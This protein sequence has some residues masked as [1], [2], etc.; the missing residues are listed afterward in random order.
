VIYVEYISRRPGVTLT[1]FHATVN[2][3]Q[4]G[5]DDE[6]GQDRLLANVGRTW[7]LGPEPEYFAVWH[8]PDQG[9]DRIDDWDR[10]FREGAAERHERLF[11]QAAR[12]DAAGCYDAL[13]EPIR[14][15]GGTYYLELFRPTGSADAIARFYE[16]RTRDRPLVL[17]LLARRVGKLGPEPGG[18]AL[19]TIPSFAALEA[20]A[21]ELDGVAEPV[22]LIAAGTYADTGRE[23]L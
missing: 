1:D 17:N 8:T 23:I 21:R 13:R 2:Q 19:W 22:E 15:R 7:R 16:E 18:L 9:L 4:A 6:H 20:L 11:R 3:A 12:I 14:A 5:W 10:I